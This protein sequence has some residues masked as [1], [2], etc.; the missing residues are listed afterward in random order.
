MTWRPAPRPFR[1]RGRSLFVVSRVC[2]QPVRLK[3][4]R[5]ATTRGWPLRRRKGIAGISDLGPDFIRALV[6]NFRLVCAR[7]C[8]DEAA[9]V[10]ASSARLAHA[11]QRRGSEVPTLHAL[12]RLS[13]E[14]HTDR[15]QG[16]P[17]L[18]AIV[19]IVLNEN[20]S[21]DNSGPISFHGGTG[22]YINLSG[23][24]VNIGHAEAG[25]G[26]GEISGVLKL[27]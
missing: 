25:T 16:W 24:G 2:Q 3:A 20:E 7:Y 18:V 26:V 27:R 1:C 21:I 15:L 8:G 14:I 22:D 12:R 5:P 11:P 4:S 19:F 13:G 6:P 17:V 23:H 10:P 9:Q